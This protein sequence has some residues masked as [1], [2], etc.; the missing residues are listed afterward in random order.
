MLTTLGEF[1]KSRYAR[2]DT[3]AQDERQA[4]HPQSMEYVRVPAR[5]LEM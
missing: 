5:S 4:I 2:L 1:Y 3:D